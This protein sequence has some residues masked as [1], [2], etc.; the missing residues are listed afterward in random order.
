MRDWGSSRCGWPAI[1]VLVAFPLY[2]DVT[3]RG[4]V[5]DQNDAPVRG[6]RVT[7]N[8]QE[9][10][11]DP[12]GNFT[13]TFPGPGDFQV[14]VAREG[15]YALKDHAV[16]VDASTE[17]TLVIN[18]VREVF[19]SENVNAETSPVDVGQAQSQQRLTGTEVNDMP[20]TNSHDPAADRSGVDVPD[21]PPAEPVPEPGGRGEQPLVPLRSDGRLEYSYW[22]PGHKDLV[23]RAWLGRLRRRWFGHEDY[24]L[25]E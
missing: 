1:A 17:I 21:G 12:T 20:I 8:S 2:A 15:Y 22:R 14:S 3:L 16:H 13:L 19:Q 10:Q 7:V 6:A 24:F 23:Q 5:V 4:R 18:S 25:R 11:T 9:A